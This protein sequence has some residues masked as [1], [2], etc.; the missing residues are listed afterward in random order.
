MKK[1]PETSYGHYAS[2][3]DVPLINAASE[4]LEVLRDFLSLAREVKKEGYS[5]DESY[6]IKKCRQVI[7]KIEKG[8]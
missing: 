6:I 3:D 2:I 7:T 5:L 4:M 8:N 1:K